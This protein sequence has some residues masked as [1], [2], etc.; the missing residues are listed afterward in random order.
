MLSKEIEKRIN[1][2]VKKSK[3][4]EIINYFYHGKEFINW[5]ISKRNKTLQALDGKFQNRWEHILKFEEVQ[6]NENP[7]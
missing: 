3:I 6:D 2:K 5:L 7:C 1:A 4:Y